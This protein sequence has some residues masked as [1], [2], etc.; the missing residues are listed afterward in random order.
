[1]PADWPEIRKRIIKEKQPLYILN[2]MQLTAGAA[3]DELVLRT[4][5]EIYRKQ[6]EADGQEKLRFVEEKIREQT[7]RPYR[8][9]TGAS[10]GTAP[11]MEE[12]LSGIKSDIQWK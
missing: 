7:G 11:S 6:L 3:P 12:L 5:K 4:D 2:F 1:M 10:A 9:S 8:L